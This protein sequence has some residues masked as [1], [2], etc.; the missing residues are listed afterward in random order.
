[1]AAAAGHDVEVYE[2][3]RLGSGASGRALGVLVPIT[4]L[5]RP[6]DRLQRAGIAA[7]PELAV[8]LSVASGIEVADFW[9]EWG[10]GRYQ[11]RLPLLFEVLRLAIEAKGGFVREESAVASPALLRP[12]YDRVLVAAG[13]GNVALVN[14]PLKVSA[15]LACRLQGHLNELVAGDNLFIVP[16]WDGTVI[17]GS[18]NWDMACAGDGSVPADKLQE[19]LRRVGAL[20]PELAAAPVI[21]SWVGYRPIEAPRLPLVK[22][23]GG[24]VLAVTGLGKV[25]I[26]LSSMIWAEIEAT[27]LHA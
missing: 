15:G 8:P 11:V 22:D 20:V 14:A 19:L 13:L 18:V 9:R 26:G 4:G 3:S 16:D 17:V 10:D 21:E 25:G 5:D 12:D 2:Q 6:V 1:M 7:W 27:F 24:G 23:M